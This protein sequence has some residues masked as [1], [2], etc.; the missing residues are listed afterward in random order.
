MLS[1]SRPEAMTVAQVPTVPVKAVIEK[2]P[3]KKNNVMIYSS[4]VW[5]SYVLGA[6]VKST[7]PAWSQPTAWAHDGTRIQREVD[8]LV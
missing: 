4:L 8:P 7:Q 5:R 1:Q 6:E 2:T 3:S